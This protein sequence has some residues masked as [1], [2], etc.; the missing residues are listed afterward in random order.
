MVACIGVHG[1]SLAAVNKA[2]SWLHP[3]QKSDL[4]RYVSSPRKSLEAKCPV[5]DLNV[6]L[7]L[8]EI[9]RLFLGRF[10]SDERKGI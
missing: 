1:I 2:A 8:I 6:F 3:M 7:G 9:H 4:G 10:V 5:H